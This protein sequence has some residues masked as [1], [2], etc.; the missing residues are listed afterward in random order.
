MTLGPVVFCSGLFT[1]L[2]LSVTRTALKPLADEQVPVFRLKKTGSGT[3][4]AARPRQPSKNWCAPHPLP[5]SS[6]VFYPLFNPRSSCGW[7]RGCGRS[8]CRFG[9]RDINEYS[10]S[11]FPQGIYLIG[12]GNIVI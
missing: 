12:D 1:F 9:A 5:P 7:H 4:A 10:V 11:N 2:V 8:I 3:A 6:F